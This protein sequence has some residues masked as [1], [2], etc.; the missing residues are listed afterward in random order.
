MMTCDTQLFLYPC[1]HYFYHSI[2][3]ANDIAQSHNR[4]T[5]TSADILAAM[6]EL[7]LGEFVEPLKQAI[8]GKG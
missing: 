5:L 2:C 7:E 8:E 1:L 3:R 4:K 6:E